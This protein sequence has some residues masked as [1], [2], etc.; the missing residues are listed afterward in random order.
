M[1]IK[2]TILCSALASLLAVAAMPTQASVITRAQFG[3]TAV[4]YG[5]ENAANGALNPTDGFLTVSGAHVTSYAPPGETGMTYTNDG[6]YGT[7]GGSAIR[8]SFASEVSAVGFTAYYNNAPVLFQVFNAQNVLL[9]SISL[10]PTDCGS[11]CG[12][13]GLRAAGISYATASLPTVNSHN[14]YADNIV[15]ERVPEPASVALFGLG[16]LGLGLRRRMA[17]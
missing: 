14:I 15:Y 12:F 5:F 4:N 11:I 17:K 1:S 7:T 8:F 10:R 16:M 6:A 3:P 13:I 2:K 9:D